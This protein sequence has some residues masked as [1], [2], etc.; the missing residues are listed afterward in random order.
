MRIAALALGWPRL[1]VCS[2]QRV[3][4]DA[5]RHRGAAVAHRAGGLAARFGARAAAGHGA[6][7]AAG[8][9]ARRPAPGGSFTVS[10]APAGNAARGRGHWADT[11][12][13]VYDFESGLPA[14]CAA[15][16]ACN[17]SCAA[18]V[19]RR[20]PA[21]ANTR[22]IPV[23]PRCAARICRRRADRFR[24]AL[25][26]RA[27]CRCDT[28]E[29]RGE[30]R[31][32]RGEHRRAYSRARDRGGPSAARCSRSA[33]SSAT[34]I[35]ACCGRPGA[36]APARISTAQ[37][38]EAER[39]L[40]VLACARNLPPDTSVQLIWGRGIASVSGLAT[41]NDQTLGFRTRADFTVR[42]GVRTR[43]PDVGLPADATAARGASAPVAAADARAKITLTDQAGKRLE[44][45]VR[46]GRA[47]GA[48]ASAPAQ[49]LPEPPVQELEFAAPFGERAVLTLNVDASL[50]DDAGR[51]P[52]NARAFRCR[53][54]STSTRRWSSSRATS[55]FSRRAPAA[56]CPSRCATSSR[57]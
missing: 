29:H 16:C 30:R 15:R 43:E 42:T 57:W 9:C 26:P 33:G 22:S 28:G 5:P 48:P 56:C 19:V 6:L 7:L 49:T 12:N 38:Q 23:A 10:C 46:G 45:R 2:W 53:S 54:H 37:L 51:R 39:D 55:A 3:P 11:R 41:R 47:A 52:A 35:S 25:H 36:K 18:R 17:H 21:A 24:A 20:S 31:V 44:P 34:S 13:W 14:D 27:R 50:V 1:Q 4:P 32:R 40:V 8:G